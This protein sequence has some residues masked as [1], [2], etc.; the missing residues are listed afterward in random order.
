MYYLHKLLKQI[1]NCYIIRIQEEREERH[2][3]K[4]VLQKTIEDPEIKS[5]IKNITEKCIK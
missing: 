1:K 4:G 2:K 3:F 5:N